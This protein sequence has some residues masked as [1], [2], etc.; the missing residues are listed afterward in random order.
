MKKKYEIPKVEKIEFDYSE[1]V[2]AS[3][4]CKGGITI[5]YEDSVYGCDSTPVKKYDPFIGDQA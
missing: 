2:V 3:P 5:S 1:T 4:Q